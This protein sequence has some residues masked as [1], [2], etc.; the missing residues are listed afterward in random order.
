MR[1]GLSS[2]AVRR[3]IL[4]ITI[5]ILAS[6]SAFAEN[7]RVA[8]TFDDLPLVSA[9]IESDDE[10]QRQATE[11]LLGALS[12]RR[13]PVVGFVNE[14]RLEPDGETNEARIAL[15][16]LWL[17]AEHELGNHSFSHPDLH[18]TPLPEYQ[19]DILKGMRVTS[20]LLAEQD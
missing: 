1:H 18:T 19:L 8:V 15:L 12:E 20:E 7:R 10:A 17:E 4:S 16:R 9:I 6:S 2:A 11:K 13:I 14:V 3:S 5:L